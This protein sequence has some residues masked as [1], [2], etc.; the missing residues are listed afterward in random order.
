[1]Y[2]T[3]SYAAA[4]RHIDSVAADRIWDDGREQCLDDGA[5]PFVYSHTINHSKLT[6]CRSRETD[7]ITPAKLKSNVLRRSSTPRGRTSD[8][9]YR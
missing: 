4:N 9:S 6:G 5:S 8:S 1:M 2:S 7:G 3:H